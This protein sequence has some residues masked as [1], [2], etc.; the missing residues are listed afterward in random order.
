MNWVAARLGVWRADPCPPAAR[1]TGRL[2]P[3]RV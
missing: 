3:G 2:D 1:I